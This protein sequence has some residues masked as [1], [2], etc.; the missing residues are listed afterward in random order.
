LVSGYIAVWMPDHPRAT[1]DGYVYEHLVVAERSLGKPLP[2]KAQVHHVN[3]IKGDNAPGN[4]VICEDA[5]YHQLLHR[6]RD[7]WL[8]CGH[9][10]WRKCPFCQQWDD[11]AHMY[12][13]KRHAIHRACKRAYDRRRRGL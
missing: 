5:A 3:E 12:V 10:D 7:A 4:L 8:A 6:R 11:P 2:K 13:N 1:P 9:A